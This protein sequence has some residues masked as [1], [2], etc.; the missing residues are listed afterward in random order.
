MGGHLTV[1]G[2]GP[3]DPGQRT[4]AV[5]SAL[6][7]AQDIVGYHTYV[8]LAGPFRDDQTVHASAN[9]VELERAR[10]ALSQAAA[11]RRVVVVSSGDPGVFGMATAVL[12]ALAQTEEPAWQAVELTILPGLSAAHACAAMAGA[13]LGHDY[14]VLSLSDNLKPW[15]VIRERLVQTAA[16]DL[17]IA[18]Y[19]PK[20]KARPWQ[21][22]EALRLVREYRSAAT[23]VMLGRDIGRP[24]AALTVLPLGEVRSE[25]VDMRTVVIIG[26]T[27]TRQFQ[28]VEGKTWV[29][30]PRWYTAGE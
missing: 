27:M 24:A 29:Y 7:Q 17:V 11:G 18:L 6:E 12:E 23:P 21:L 13:P 16:I 28:S 2:M 10:F 19:N 22:D 9:R 5:Q 3:G 1:V 26:S 25:Q 15:S 14:C 8:E 4:P 30:T 20:S